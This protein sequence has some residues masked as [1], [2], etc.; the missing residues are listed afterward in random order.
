MRN[1][2]PCTAPSLQHFSAIA[3]AKD[4]PRDGQLRA[5]QPRIG[6][7]Y[8][9][10][11]RVCPALESLAP[12]QVTP[13]ERQV[14]LHCYEGE[15]IPLSLLKDAIW[16]NQ[17]D[18]LKATCQY[19]CVSPPETYDH[20]LPKKKYPEFSVHLRNLIPCCADCNRDRGDRWKNAQGERLYIHL[21]D[22]P[23]EEDREVLFAELDMSH[24]PRAIFRLEMG[25]ARSQL[26][27]PLLE[28]HITEL[29]LLAKYARVAPGRLSEHHLSIY[30]HRKW[31]K[32]AKITEILKDQLSQEK[33]L[34]GVHHWKVALLRAVI[35]TP[36]FVDWALNTPPSVWEEKDEAHA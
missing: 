28:R 30:A 35:Q 6:G 10:Y 16:S 17:T 29:K 13:E 11:D 22:D 34:Y 9:S 32:Q 7:A 15:T 19:C 2:K 33:E 20:Y 12:L 27:Y 21:Y 25:Q 31:L 23:V 3:A 18:L 8:G 14:L 1:L 26:F 36:Q 4:P 5:L 24:L